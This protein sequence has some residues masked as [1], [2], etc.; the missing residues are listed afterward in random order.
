MAT[1][2][3]TNPIKQHTSRPSST[4]S[5]TSQVSEQSSNKINKSDIVRPI[6]KPS[7]VS[8]PESSTKRNSTPN[9]SSVIDLTM[10]LFSQYKKSLNE[11]SSPT[12]KQHTHSHSNK[13]SSSSSQRSSSTVHNSKQ[14]FATK[15]P[16][17]KLPAG[18]FL[19]EALSGAAAPKMSTSPLTVD[20]DRCV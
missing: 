20:D 17:E 4:D 8:Q 3:A 19:K 7:I 13:D 5:V 9:F 10:D 6:A 18:S 2:V 15:L 1:R 11:S 14:Q 12:L 16:S